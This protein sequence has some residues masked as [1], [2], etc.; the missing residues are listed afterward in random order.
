MVTLKYLLNI[1]I[2]FFT[3]NLYGQNSNQIVHDSTF[4]ILAKFIS[5]NEGDKLHS[6]RFK[7]I[8]CLE[9]N[10]KLKDTITVWYYNYSQPDTTLNDVLLI[11]D[12][13]DYQIQSQ[14]IKEK[15]KCFNGNG[16][17]GIQKAKIEFIDFKYWEGC[18]TG[19]GECKPMI[20]TK[21]KSEINWFLI[22]PCGGTSTSIKIT[23]DKFVENLKLNSNNCPPIL[24]LT[25][26][27]EGK[28]NASML[29]CGLGGTVIFNLKIK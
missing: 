13:N 15:L 26:L 8:K 29:A 16:S 9:N 24:E 1:L 28:Y 11:I 21:T 20:F 14:R 6:A 18:E 19:K 7:V 4:K 5:F 12:K 23:G 27:N 3:L 22:M 10:I 25:N 2:L 17:Y